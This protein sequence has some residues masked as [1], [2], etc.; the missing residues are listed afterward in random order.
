MYS[1]FVTSNNGYGPCI[2]WIELLLHWNDSVIGIIVVVRLLISAIAIVPFVTVNS[3]Q[4]N[5]HQVEIYGCVVMER[6]SSH[7]YA[8]VANNAVIQI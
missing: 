7:L 6:D 2:R 5:W 1:V 3:E 4:F 8:R